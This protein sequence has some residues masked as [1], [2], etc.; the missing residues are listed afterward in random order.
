M[1]RGTLYRCCI[2][3]FETHDTSVNATLS[4]CTRLKILALRIPYHTPSFSQVIN[5]IA[6]VQPSSLENIGLYLNQY[7]DCLEPRTVDWERLNSMVEQHQNSELVAKCYFER[8]YLGAKNEVLWG[9][10]HPPRSHDDAY[11]QADP[12]SL[13]PEA[14]S[15]RWRRLT[16]HLIRKTHGRV[17]LYDLK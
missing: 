3:G 16:Y 15:R 6:R 17:E 14:C 4:R 9:D 10:W 2:I 12:Q 8:P 7:P 5:L 11:F 1:V 13:F